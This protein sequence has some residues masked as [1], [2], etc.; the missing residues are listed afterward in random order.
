V[1]G[2]FA[3]GRLSDRLL[4]RGNARA[5]ILVPAVCLLALGP[6]LTPG[7]MATSIVAALPLLTVGAFL[8]AAPNAP[9][10]AARLDIMH[11]RLWGRAEG[12]RTV[13]RT[14]GEAIAPVLFGYVSQYL[15]GMPGL[16]AGSIGGSASGHVA[17]ATGLEYT[18]LLFLG[19]LLVAGL[20]LLPAL[21]SYPRDVATAN[22][23]LEATRRG[24]AD[25]E[26]EGRSPVPA[27][28]QPRSGKA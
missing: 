8:L 10:D 15:F 5:R 3:G 26:P 24:R 11:P 19:P 18:L 25:R 6:V 20:L 1:L 21:R 13:L 22:A 7:V 17:S 16:G 27:R 12:V 4:R 14:L 2:V 9:M 23:S 28:T